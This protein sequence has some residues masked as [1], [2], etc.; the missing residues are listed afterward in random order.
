V[1][2]VLENLQASAVI[3]LKYMSSD[4]SKFIATVRGFPQR[5]VLSI[6]AINSAYPLSGEPLTAKNGSQHA[7]K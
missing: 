2:L 7:H 5:F 6:S 3:T 4:A 1:R